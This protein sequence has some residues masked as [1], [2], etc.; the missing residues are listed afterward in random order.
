MKTEQLSGNQSKI[1]TIKI[2]KTTM[3][4]ASDV[5]FEHTNP[6]TCEVTFQ[7]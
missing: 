7:L 6:E 5:K 1:I 4:C 3:M 2:R